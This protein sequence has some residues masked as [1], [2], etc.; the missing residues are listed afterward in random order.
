MADVFREMF[1]SDRHPRMRFELIRDDVRGWS[2][3]ALPDDPDEDGHYGGWSVHEG[4][5]AFPTGEQNAES[6]RRWATERDW[7]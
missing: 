4:D 6:L 5:V 2:V 1:R 3:Y 7:R